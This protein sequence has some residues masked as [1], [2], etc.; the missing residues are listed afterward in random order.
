MA[1]ARSRSRGS[2]PPAGQPPTKHAPAPTASSLSAGAPTPD[3]AA[4]AATPPEPPLTP[5]AEPAP[6]GAAA[7]APAP[8][9]LVP[10]AATAGAASPA[11]S[12]PEPQPPAEP[13]ADTTAAAAP[14]PARRGW[15]TALW[16]GYQ[17]EGRRDLR[18]DF[19]RGFAV[20]AMVVDHIGGPSW[21]YALTG[22]NRFYTSAA[23]GFI[24]ISGMLV[25]VVYGRI[26]ARDGFAA[27]VRRAVERAGV[28]YLLTVGVTL[29]LLLVTELLDLPGA[30]GVYLTDPLA[31]VAGILT[32]HRTYYLI[33][34]MVLYTLLLAVAP[35][36]LYLLVQ[37]QTRLVLAA[38]WGLWLLFQIVPDQAEIP[39]TIAGNYL[40]HFSAWQVFFFTAM[41]LGFHRDRIAPW[42]PPLRQRIL[43]VLS[44]LGVAGLVLLYR[45]GDGLWAW[46]PFTAPAL[47]DPNDLFVLIFAKGDVRPGRIVASIVVFGFLY[48]LVSVAWRPLYR[49]LGWL[50]MPLGQNAL[51]A[52]TAHI[53]LVVLLG[54]ALE[55]LSA[56]DRQSR[57]LNTA[58]QLGATLVIWGLIKGRVGFPSPQHRVRWALVPAALGVAVL[59]IMPLDPS[60][61]QPGWAEPPVA[62]AASSPRRAANPFGTPIPRR[63]GANP[64][65]LPAPPP[66]PDPRQAAVSW[67]AAE[68]NDLPEYVGP[69]RG[70]FLERSFFS[71]AL[72]REMP[73]F[74]YLPPQYD[75]ADRSYPVLY[76][77]HGAS[78]A[79]EE[80]PATGLVDL[81]DR[82]I[83]ARELEP[84]IVVL[85]QGDF[86]YWLN[87]AWEGP[88]WGD[89]VTRDLVAH[90]D[91]SYR[92]LRRPHR[93]AIG[94]LSVGGTAALA[95][96]F[97]WPQRFGIAAAHMPA[98]RED[99]SE[100]SFLGE[101]EDF[102]ARDPVSLA[103]RLSSLDQLQIWLDGG[104][105]DDWYPRLAMLHEVL[106]DRGIEHH[107]WI[108]PGDHDLGD[109]AR[110]IPEY[111]RF[112][113]RALNRR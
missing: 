63:A 22:G 3:A 60:P 36:A 81:L 42:F 79:F 20:F 101:D 11:V 100:I 16:G 54:I 109:M 106:L 47:A 98:L 78:G 93:R 38:S 71:R 83:Q 108:W 26:V 104:D 57:A 82:G 105:E 72:G 30:T 28:L 103:Q 39:W 1:R 31:L 69:I 7:A 66:L 17:G 5:S 52:Y 74:V 84:F 46:L 37:G 2:P 35:L 59:L 10:N 15:W 73:Y 89:Y 53:V 94:G 33:D 95:H 76:M 27:G 70:R 23:E 87:H 45:L 4:G 92:T 96:A 9:E 25:G 77:L 110:H 112:Y 14:P 51:Y 19:L 107:W 50:L 62:E 32:L 68:R 29:P 97:T 61:T 65:G 40:F 85:P 49:A 56:L 111:L 88:R 12:Q 6:H 55:P 21:L 99:N 113:S 75:G 91:G 90:V 18:L 43:L 67:S 80:W 64:P 48:L 41:A 102:A 34:V 86:G 8:A 58:L 24:F 13:A 44:G